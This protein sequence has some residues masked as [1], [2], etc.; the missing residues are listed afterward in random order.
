MPR[1]WC[2]LRMDE[3]SYL[4]A[5]RLNLECSIAMVYADGF[6]VVSNCRN[7][8][9]T[10][11]YVHTREPP[12]E[13][14]TITYSFYLGTMGRAFKGRALVR[15][16][17][18]LPQPRGGEPSFG[19]GLEFEGLEI[20]AQRWISERIDSEEAERI[21]RAKGPVI[22]TK[23]LNLDTQEFVA[24]DK[25]FDSLGINTEPEEAFRPKGFMP[26]SRPEPENVQPEPEKKSK[27]RVKAAV[28]PE[29]DP[30]PDVPPGAETET[31]NPEPGP[32]SL[33]IVDLTD[34]FQILLYPFD[35]DGK[36]SEATIELT[37][38]FAEQGDELELSDMAPRSPVPLLLCP[39]QAYRL[40]LTE[41]HN[42]HPDLDTPVRHVSI[43]A[44]WRALIAQ[45]GLHVVHRSDDTR[46]HIIAPAGRKTL[47]EETLSNVLSEG[48]REKT[49]VHSQLAVIG[50]GPGET[51]TE[52]EIE[53]VIDLGLF[54]T[55]LLIR[56][57]QGDEHVI[58]EPKLGLH[59]LY[60]DLMER[61]AI[62]LDATYGF[63]IH[64]DPI[65]EE[66]V[67]EELATMKEVTNLNIKLEDVE[68]ELEAADLTDWWSDLAHRLL[69]ATRLLMSQA[70]VGH[71]DKVLLIERDGNWPTL[72][73]LLEEQLGSRSEKV[74]LVALWALFAQRV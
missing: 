26:E 40:S 31:E 46:L 28:G 68:L 17:R 25:L 37:P 29:P 54:E 38:R 57:V 32:Q 1:T 65:A 45:V 14:T 58:H 47:V 66:I 61:A 34:T 43:E 2:H 63:E 19:V 8:S 55:R 15:W 59:A 5:R 36:Q 21:A 52:R 11:A 24:V 60:N 18:T 53:L 49:Q 71:V 23:G 42:N 70:Q 67:R 27:T 62:T 16:V 50:A 10:G 64:D 9:E 22:S 72:D 30:E 39:D 56:T 44:G 35:P 13:G 6:R 51:E 12:V 69:D 33:V 4:K 20:V 73:E 48:W 7:I 74:D 41:V 3:E